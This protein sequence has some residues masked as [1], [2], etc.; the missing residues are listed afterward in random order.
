MI[1]EQLVEES[2]V[3]KHITSVAR[4]Q[5]VPVCNSHIAE[6]VLS[7]KSNS[8]MFCGN[9]NT[10]LKK[11]ILFSVTYIREINPLRDLHTMFINKYIKMRYMK[12][13]DINSTSFALIWK[14]QQCQSQW[15]IL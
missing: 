7:G 8:T 2:R 14:A 4:Q 10:A 6:Q 13:Y 5:D 3:A 12:Q 11:I 1:T 9:F 15:S